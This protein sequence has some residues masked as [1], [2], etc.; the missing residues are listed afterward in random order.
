MSNYLIAFLTN[1]RFDYY[2]LL[3]I[4]F[5]TMD[6]DPLMHWEEIKGLFSSMHGEVLRFILAYQVPL[7]KLIRFELA[8]R[9]HDENHNWCGFDK[10]EEIWL[11]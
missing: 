4:R 1:L 9:G 3:D 7:E 5:I 10:A 2:H 6:E 11:K 8:A